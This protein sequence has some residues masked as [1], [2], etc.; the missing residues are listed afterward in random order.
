MGW[1]V[2]E[3]KRERPA[4]QKAQQEKERA[5]EKIPFYGDEII[6]IYE[7][8]KVWVALRPIVENLGLNWSK[9]YRKILADP[10]LSSTVAQKATVAQDGKERKLLC[11]PVEYLNGFLFKIN[12][13]KVKDEKVRER[14]SD[15]R[16]S[17]TEPS[18]N[19]SLME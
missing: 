6:A 16:K 11:L 9:Q 13:N 8:G 4:E 10:V 18:T 15:T 1:N 3:V 14:I 17:A 5:L 2:R 12:P 19:T 7:N